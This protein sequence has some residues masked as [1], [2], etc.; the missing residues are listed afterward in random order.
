MK[1]KVIHSKNCENSPKN[2]LVEQIA[3][4]LL[5]GEKVNESIYADTVRIR[6]NSGEEDCLKKDIKPKIFRLVHEGIRE[7]VVE[8][9]ISHGSMG[10]SSLRL[11]YDKATIDIGILIEFNSAAA[12]FVT[13]ISLY[14]LL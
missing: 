4:E 1:C 12:K 5:C 13:R 14:D 9:T 6:S 2:T 11:K 10:F 3:I 7:V 8:S